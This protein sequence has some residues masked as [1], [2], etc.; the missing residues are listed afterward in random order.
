MLFLLALSPI[1]WL[2]F[3]LSGLKMSGY[4]ACPIAL[5][6]ALAVALL[7]EDMTLSHAVMAVL[8]GLA[9]AC[10]PILLVIIAAIFT[11]NLSLYT[12]GMDTIKRMLT[13]VSTDRR[14]LVLLIGWGFGSFLEGMAGFGTAIAIPAS[15]LA[16]IGFNPLLS[17]LVCLIANSVPTAFGSIGIPVVTLGQVSG[18]DSAV[19]AK[20]VALQLAPI[21]LLCPFLMVIATGG[22][23]KALKGVFLLTLAAGVCFIVPE[24]IVASLMGAELAVIAGSIGAM[25]AIVIGAKLTK[26]ID[27]QY[28]IDT[29]EEKTATPITTKR[30][31]IAWLPFILIFIFLLFTSKLIPAIHDPLN[32]IKTSVLIYSGNGGTPYTFTWIATPGVLILLAAFIGGRVQKASFS[33]MF[34]VLGKTVIGLYTTIITIISVIATAEVM[35]FSGMTTEI[36]ETAVAVTGTAYP[37]IAPFIGSIGTF[38]T[39]SATSSSVLF[40]KLQADSALA[41]QANQV[42]ITAANPTGACAGKMISPQSIAIAVAATGLAGRDGEL[43]KAAVK[44]YIPFII[45]M[46]CIVYFGQIFVS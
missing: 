24:L 33:E 16:G 18:I 3:A 10:W 17:A 11:Y 25:A 13:T 39:G 45:L 43:L 32:L 36:A 26:S 14:I 42:W 41:I 44:Y 2:I 23:I 22:S 21:S 8:Q 15:M 38:I 6:I 5:I 40:G 27:P 9:L 31:L 34:S 12:K 1:L 19:L 37:A 4:K 35:G 30:A 20:Y 46:G 28:Q 7:C 29:K